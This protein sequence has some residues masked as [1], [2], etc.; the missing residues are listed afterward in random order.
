MFARSVLLVAPD[1]AD[2]TALAEAIRGAGWSLETSSALAGV[3]AGRFDVVVDVRLRAA[4]V[5][6]PPPSDLSDAYVELDPT[7]DPRTALLPAIVE[8]VARRRAAER[9]LRVVAETDTLT[10]L[11]TRTAFLAALDGAARAHD[12]ALIVTDLARFHVVVRALGY[13]VGDVI[14]Q[15]TARRVR[16]VAGPEVTLGRLSADQLGLVVS[17][18][19]AAAA[20]KLVGQ[21]ERA[22]AAPHVHQGRELYVATALGWV[23]HAR[24]E[25]EAERFVE[26]A[27]QALSSAK[28]RGGTTASEYRPSTMP[29]DRATILELDGGLR[30]AVA[31]GDFFLVH[32]PKVTLAD[33]RFVGFESLLRW[34]RAD[35]RIISPLEFIPALESTG[36][37]D[38]VTRRSLGVA[39]QL[40]ARLSGRLGHTVRAAVNVSPTQLGTPGFV[41]RVLTALDEAHVSPNHVELELTESALVKQEV[42]AR[43]QLE[44]LSR[45]GLR[46]ALDDFGTGFSSLSYLHSLPFDVIKIDRTFVANLENNPRSRA[47][48]AT[49]VDLARALSLDVVAEGVE[50][51]AQRDVLVDLG[52]IYAQGWLFS[53]PL[54]AESLER[55]AWGEAA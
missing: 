36:L 55:F 12:V 4:R 11:L 6:D 43:Q 17:H 20:T 54:P 24:G 42:I 16:D 23:H 40:A 52:C 30:A 19:D 9:A 14:L 18:T 15:T 51:P 41:E 48:A 21:L 34:K 8:A 45:A 3:E 31:R 10:G 28:Q 1:G 47:V 29:P 37:I 44:A 25:A 26:E 35:G 13:R 39:G 50:T 38:P 22:L 33:A 7:D 5:A 49:I 32:Q 53:K 46:L 27:L 2:T